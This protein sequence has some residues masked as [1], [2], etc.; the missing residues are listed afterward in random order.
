M[1]DKLAKEAEFA[2]QLEEARREQER[3]LVNSQKQKVSDFYDDFLSQRHPAYTQAQKVISEL[4]LDPENQT[5]E[6]IDLQLTKKE[7]V[8]APTLTYSKQISNQGHLE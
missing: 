3:L 8:I 6:L 1:V 7:K 5:P 4:N 2:R